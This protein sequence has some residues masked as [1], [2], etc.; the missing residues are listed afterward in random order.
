MTQ[1]TDTLTQ[2]IAATEAPHVDF[3]ST[4]TDNTAITQDPNDVMQRLGVSGADT[5]SARSEASFNTRFSLATDDAVAATDAAAYVWRPGALVAD[6]L[7]LQDATAIGMRW[8]VILADTQLLTDALTRAYPVALVDTATL[9][10]A[11]STV[12]GVITIEALAL[13]DSPLPALRYART[14]VDLL[15]LSDSTRNF[16]GA[17]VVESIAVTEDLSRM[18]RATPTLADTLSLTDVLG[19]SMI[20]RVMAADTI[21][22]T[23]AQA[24]RMIF[25]GVLVDGID[26]AAA[27]LSP[28]GGVTTWAVNAHN[29]ATTEYTNYDFNSFATVGNR[30]LGASATGLYELLG[31]DDAGT[32]II[33]TIRS[34]LAQFA[35]THLAAFKAAYLGVTGGGDYVLRI[36]DGQ[37]HSWDY[38]VV[39]ESGRST[40]VKV[41]KGLRA[42]YFAF[43]LISTGQD[44]DLDLVEF[45][46]VVMQRRG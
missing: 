27:Y 5:F 16:F 9:T 28:G 21:E 10:E 25:A 1:Y 18:F 34:G 12:R 43:E 19:H 37:G 8:G 33:A 26:L 31:D 3:A 29:G 17:G 35:G 22:V 46:P 38:A 40:K 20:L 24:L 39:A 23:A 4:L 14:L 36:I 13:V 15:A 11:T 42:R 45:V 6:V 7:S 44:F 2:A 30:Y 32:D 41:G